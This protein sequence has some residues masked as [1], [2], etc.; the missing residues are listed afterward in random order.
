VV[1]GTDGGKIGA[2]VLSPFAKAGTTSA[3]PYNH[4]SLL[5]SIEDSFSLPRLGYA[6]APGVN[7]FGAD[8]F[9]TGH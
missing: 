8:V 3:V 5:A 4:Y 1:G 9:N 6:R 7:T 2:L